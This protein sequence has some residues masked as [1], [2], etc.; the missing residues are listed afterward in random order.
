MKKPVA[1]VTGATGFTGWH[2]VKHLLNNNY[3]VIATDIRGSADPIFN[4]TTFIT[5]DLTD[6]YN[7]R[8][9]DPFINAIKHANYIFH[10]AGLFNY[11]ASYKNLCKVNIEGTENLFNIV[12]WHNNISRIVVWSAGGVFGNFDHIPL[13]AT[14][15]MP[16][17]TDNSYLLSK[18]LQE[19]KSLIFGS[20][21]SIPVTVIRPSAVYGPK[22]TYGIA[23]S[24]TTLLKSKVGSVIGSGQN[25]GSLV[26]V[27]DV[28][29]AAEFL[30]NNENAVGEIYHVTD[31]ALYNN[32][33]I[34][35]HLSKCCGAVF[36]PFK[37][38][39]W[40]ALMLAKLA[41]IDPELIHL[42]TINAWI[43]NEKIKK[44][45]FRFKYP[46]TKIGLAETVKWYKINPR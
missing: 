6:W 36:L 43:S 12:Q 22:S 25:K 17:K 26:H 5:A 16:T 46:D 44:L 37:I 41:K 11:A 15:D 30:V 42:T 31:D 32:A 8:E 29:R 23:L 9:N 13:P 33:E 27:E 7:L 19:Q 45:G 35:K 20:M 3:E 40:L 10:I 28:V 34:A 4:S 18:L 1:L 2:M 39:K 38:P 21:H 14:E 24:I